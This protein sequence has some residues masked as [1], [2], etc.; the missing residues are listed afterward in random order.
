MSCASATCSSFASV[1]PPAIRPAT[2]GRVPWREALRAAL[3]AIARFHAGH[4]QRRTLIELNDHLLADIGVT[5]GKAL[6]E[7]RKFFWQ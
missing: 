7:A 4:N 3:A 6:C 5:R 1:D 2:L